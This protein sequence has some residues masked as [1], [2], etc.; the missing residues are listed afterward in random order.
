MNHEYLSTLSGRDFRLNNRSFLVVLKGSGSSVPFFSSALRERF[1]DVPIK[2]GGM[3]IKWKGYGLVVDPGI[4]FMDNMHA[5]GLHI[6]DIN[7]VIVTHNHIDHNGDLSR[8]DDMASQL[9]RT[10]IV[11]YVDK[12]TET[13]NRG[14][15]SML[16]PENWHGLDLGL[17]VLLNN[18]EDITEDIHMDIFPTQHILK[19]GVKIGKEKDDYEKTTYALKMTFKDNGV[20]RAI[21]GFTSDTQYLD[22]L[23]DFFRECDYIVANISETNEDD[24]LRQVLKDTHLGYTGCAKLLEAC[25]TS[26]AKGAL[27]GGNTIFILSEFWAGKGD[28]RRELVRSLREKTKYDYIYPGDV[29]MLF[30]LDQPTFLCDFCNGE[31]VIDHLHTIRSGPEY[32]ILR[33]IC[34]HCIL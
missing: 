11:L 28:V 6:N 32:S 33:N 26:S 2:G 14:Q 22:E 4:N 13:A 23:G 15:M 29:G 18:G 19:K 3:F 8:I 7:A 25:K 12:D 1:H 34:E 17:D 9:E 10:N 20:A 21:V 5:R 24:Y 16:K 30:F 27:T 31:E